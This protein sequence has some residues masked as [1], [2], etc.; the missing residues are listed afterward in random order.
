MKRIPILL[1]LGLLFLLLSPPVAGMA[2]VA[3]TNAVLSV[4]DPGHS[5]EIDDLGYSQLAIGPD[6]LYWRTGTR[7]M[8][9]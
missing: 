1:I 4:V 2:S 8:F 6:T 9:R 7:P 5:P 3:G